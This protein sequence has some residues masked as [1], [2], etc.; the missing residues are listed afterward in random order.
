MNE[1][2]HLRELLLD[3]KL[4]LLSEDERE[5]TDE[6]IFEESEFSALLEEVE[7]DLLDDYRS[8]RLTAADRVRV[9]R[10]FSPA[11]RAGMTIRA[12]KPVE[13]RHRG[14]L[15]LPFLALPLAAAVIVA[16]V[17]IP[18]RRSGSPPSSGIAQQPAETA[19]PPNPTAVASPQ[20]QVA[21][22]LLTP[23]VTRD[24]S[25]LRLALTPATSRVRIQWMVPAQTSGMT[26]SLTVSQ[27]SG[28]VLALANDKDI[29]VINGQ[30]ITEFSVSPAVFRD[31]SG[32]CLLTVRAL[33]EPAKPIRQYRI[34][35]QHR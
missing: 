19:K 12:P 11:E 25:T 3:Y 16:M 35:I 31:S 27:V 23:D 8:G 30:R 28:T 7:Y 13:P 26:F 1:A 29:Q 6:R 24:D 9:E 10:A 15:L 34:T 20:D 32:D 5:R 21:T 22:L 33:A 14:L 4:G 17:L 2:D 18:G